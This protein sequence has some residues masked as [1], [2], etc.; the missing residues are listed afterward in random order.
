LVLASLEVYKVLVVEFLA[1]S[2]QLVL[3]FLDHWL[4]VVSLDLSLVYP[5]LDEVYSLVAESLDPL[6]VE[7]Y[8]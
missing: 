5:E 6:M 7:E 1:L 2:I 4:V 3:A 8:P